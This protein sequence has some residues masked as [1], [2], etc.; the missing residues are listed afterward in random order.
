MNVEIWN[1]AARSFFFGNTLIRLKTHVGVP[2]TL[3]WYNR[4]KLCT[5]AAHAL[6]DKIVQ[7]YALRQRTLCGIKSS[8]TMRPGSASFAG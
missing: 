5:Q 6:R 7:N 2:R 8:K 4:P 3:S 1:E